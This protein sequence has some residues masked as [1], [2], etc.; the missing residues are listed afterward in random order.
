MLHP[1]GWKDP[2]NHPVFAPRHGQITTKQVGHAAPCSPS[3]KRRLESDFRMSRL[4]Q[5]NMYPLVLRCFGAQ[6]TLLWINLRCFKSV[7]EVR[8]VADTFFY[9]SGN[10]A[11]VRHVGDTCPSLHQL[12]LKS[13]SD[14]KRE[15]VFNQ[16]RMGS[17]LFLGV[18]TWD[19]VLF[20][21]NMHP[22]DHSHQSHLSPLGLHLEHMSAKRCNCPD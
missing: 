8:D 7:E 22:G 15:L 3:K 6:T 9:A 16:F 13:T 21:Q 10:W 12:K 14:P 17:A 18:L 5:E 1:P 19:W 2:E 20:I 11:S 4:W